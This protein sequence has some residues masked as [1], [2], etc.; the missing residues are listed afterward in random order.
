MISHLLL[1]HVWTSYIPLKLLGAC[2][3][4]HHNVADPNLF[5]VRDRFHV[6]Q[7]FCGQGGIVLF[8]AWILHLQ[9]SFSHLRGPV[10]GQ[11]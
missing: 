5:G 1:L 4:K 11:L 9:W 3:Q 6:G 10:P 7:F 2:M 8:T